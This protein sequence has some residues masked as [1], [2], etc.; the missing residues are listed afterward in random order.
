[1]FWL[2]NRLPHDWKEKVEEQKKLTDEQLE[3]LRKIT[4]ERMIANL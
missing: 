3:M 4:Y 1:M 2:K